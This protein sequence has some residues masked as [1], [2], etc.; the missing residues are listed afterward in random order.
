MGNYLQI[1][2]LYWS[3]KHDFSDASAIKQI[4]K[5]SVEVPP[6]DELISPIST[7]A[8][9]TKFENIT[10]MASTAVNE[11]LLT[12]DTDNK[13]EKWCSIVVKCIR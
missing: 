7:S 8:M 9:K 5:M 13:R 4:P 3:R 12:P 1:Q 2:N 10:T 11:C 6:S